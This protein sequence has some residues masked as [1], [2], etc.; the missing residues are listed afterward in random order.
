MLSARA[1]TLKDSGVGLPP[2]GRGGSAPVE[3]CLDLGAAR[4]GRLGA[5][6]CHGECGSGRGEAKR[7]LQGAPLGEARRR[8]PRRRCRPPPCCPR[9]PLSNGATG[10]RSSADDT[11]AP[12]GPSV[13]ID[14]RWSRLPQPV[15]GRAALAVSCHREAREALGFPLVHD[16][17]LRALEKG[18][19]H[20]LHRGVVQHDRA[21]RRRKPSPSRPAWCP[22][23]SRTAAGP[24]PRPRSPRQTARSARG[25]GGSWRREPRRGSSGRPHLP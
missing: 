15:S 4:D 3:E 23:E 21:R 8:A 22:R 1:W 24:S 13:T 20:R 19:L 11:Q 18:R 12:A 9:H 5:E 17:H 2:R 25:S 14:S 10:P 7:I 6:A 16:E